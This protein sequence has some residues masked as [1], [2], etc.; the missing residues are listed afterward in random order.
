MLTKEQ[1]FTVLKSVFP[2]SKSP[3]EL[4]DT[5]FDE[6]SKR[7][8]SN[9][10]LIMFLAQCGHE[11]QNFTRLEENLNY[12]AK[13]LYNVFRKYFPTMTIAEAYERQ[14][15]MIANKVYANRL[16]N[17]STCTNDGY[18]YR[19]RGLIQITGKDNYRRLAYDTGINC[20]FKEN[21]KLRGRRIHYI[22]KYTPVVLH[23]Y[24]VSCAAK[25]RIC[26]KQGLCMARG[27]DFRNNCYSSFF[28]VFIHRL[29][30]FP[31]IEALVY[32]IT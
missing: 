23:V 7:N 28:C 30:V 17:G 14:P 22:L 4:I 29:Q 10:D 32:M 16:G 18:L 21:P 25:L 1:I 20:G 31:R 24:F 3:L 8:F 9:K 19:G 5:I 15:K 27:L 26:C 13:A 11:S 6:A 12:S 2:N